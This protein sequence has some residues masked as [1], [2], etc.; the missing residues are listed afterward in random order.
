MGI[1][2]ALGTTKESVEAR[3]TGVA[4]NM[5]YP[6]DGNRFG[7]IRKKTNVKSSYQWEHAYANLSAIG[8]LYMSSLAK[9]YP[10]HYFG[11]VSPGMT[12]ESLNP[13]HVDNASLGLVLKLLACRFLMFPLLKRWEIVQDIEDSAA[14]FKR[15]LTGEDWDYPNGTFVGARR[16][17]SGPICD[18][19]SLPSGKIFLNQSMQQIAYEAV[20]NFLP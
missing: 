17:T 6:N 4:Y 11:T 16:G 14:Y 7:I 18:Q 10:H 1:V 5:H 3:L 19:S 15:A 8:V 9:Y 2:P 13:R 20:Q 12:Q